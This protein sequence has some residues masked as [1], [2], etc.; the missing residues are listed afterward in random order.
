MALKPKEEI[1]RK[2]TRMDQFFSPWR[3]G[4]GRRSLNG[5]AD[6]DPSRFCDHGPGWGESQHIN[7]G[8]VPLKLYTIYAPPNHRDG[9]VHHTEGMRRLTTN[10]LTQDDGMTFWASA[11]FCKGGQAEFCACHER[12]LTTRCSGRAVARPAAKTGAFG[13]G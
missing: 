3:K 12:R 1:G 9:V 13:V 4:P 7:T 8:S 5:A 10:T 6:G 11:H 2:F